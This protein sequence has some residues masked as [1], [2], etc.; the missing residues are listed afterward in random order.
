MQDSIFTKLAKGEIPCEKIYEDDT[1]MAFLDIHPITPGH[2]LVIPKEQVAHF[3]E[4][5]DTTYTS[6][7]SAVKKVAKRIKSVTGAERVCIRVEGFDVPHTHVHVYPC[8]TPEDFYGEPGR[9][10]KEPDHPALAEM[11]KKLVF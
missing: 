8:N 10:S 2:T 3:E 6:L 5:N 4:L 1:V 7:F 9:L 11:A